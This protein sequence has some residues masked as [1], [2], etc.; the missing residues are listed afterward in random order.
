MN[1]Y[2]IIIHKMSSVYSVKN[3]SYTWN[4][5]DEKLWAVG[6]WTGVGHREHIRLVVFEIRVEFVFEVAAPNRRAASAVS[7][8]IACLYHE[9]FDYSME[10]V[11]VVV[12]VARVNCEV[13][14]A[15]R[16]PFNFNPEYIF[17]MFW[18]LKEIFFLYNNHIS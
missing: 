13:L 15:L 11:A 1:N 6:I 5:S 2:Q 7:L 8:W 14:N 4:D 9:L 18:L 12:A 10:D 3:D 16:T 17:L